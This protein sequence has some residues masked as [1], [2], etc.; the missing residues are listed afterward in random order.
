[1]ETVKVNLC[2]NE[3]LVTQIDF[4]ESPIEVH[5]QLVDLIDETL[6]E[7]HLEI[8]SLSTTSN[9]ERTMRE[10]MFKKLM[11]VRDLVSNTK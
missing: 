10:S 1:M 11:E 8:E 9:I 5:R 7:N 2:L 4:Q 3:D 6:Y